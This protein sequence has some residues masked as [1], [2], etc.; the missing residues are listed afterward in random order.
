MDLVA[1]PFM[2][3]CALGNG[4]HLAI[5]SWTH[6]ERLAF[7]FIRAVLTQLVLV[8]V[9]SYYHGSV[10]RHPYFSWYYGFTLV[11]EAEGRFAVAFASGRYDEPKGFAPTFEWIINELG[12]VIRDY[13]SWKPET[14]HDVIPHELLYVL[15]SDSGKW[16]CFDPFRKVV[17]GYNNE[18]E[19]SGGLRQ[20][21]QNV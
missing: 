13:H 9:L 15:P 2:T 20:G 16:I 21:A 8:L 1:L 12:S 17:D 5:G 14:T 19:F 11:C 6:P 4:C 3:S 7:Q 18:F 10:S